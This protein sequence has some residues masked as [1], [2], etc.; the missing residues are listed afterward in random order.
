MS[1]SSLGIGSGIDLEGM[2]QMLM[3]VEARPLQM[4]ANKNQSFQT[5]LSAYSM[6]QSAVANF[7]GTVRGLANISQYQRTTAGSTQPDLATISAGSTASNGS[8]NLSVSQL[9]QSQRLVAGGVASDKEEIGTGKFTITFGQITGG[10]FNEDTGLYQSTDTDDGPSNPSFVIAGAAAATITITNDNNSLIG[11]RDAINA[12]GIGVTATIVN[13]GT[14]KPFRLTLTNAATGEKSSMQIVVDGDRGLEDLL[15]YDPGTAQNMTQTAMARNAEFTLDGIRI[16][17]ATNTVTDVLEGVTITLRG[18]SSDK[19]S[20]TTLSVNR[21]TGAAA[22]AV[23]ELVKAY[24]DL[25]NTLKELTSFDPETRQ[26]SVLTG[27]S[28]VRSIQT[29]MRRVLSQSI[30]GGIDGFRTLADVGVTMNK[31]GVLEIDS[32]RLNAAIDKD[33]NAFVAMFAEGGMS[34]NPAITFASAAG[35]TKT[36]SFEV[37]ITQ[38]ATKGHYALEIDSGAL[39]L[40]GTSDADRSM[41]ITL[42]GVSR[43]ITLS[44]KSYSESELATELQTQINNAFTGAGLNVTAEDGVLKLTSDAYGSATTINITPTGGMGDVLSNGTFT[45]GLDVAGTI[46]GIVGVG[47]GQTLT[48]AANS[49]TD[50]LKLTITGEESGIRGTVSFTKGYAYQFQMMADELLNENGTIRSHI[51]GMNRNIEQTQKEFATIEAR[52]ERTEKAYRR[53][54]VA[55]DVLLAKLNQQ[56]AYLTTQLQAISGLWQTSSSK[57]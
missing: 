19:A 41:L 36:G 49:E 53:Q 2:V 54:F 34:S 17:K 8:Y 38:V 44:E 16:S 5:K 6:V 9:A 20:T 21:D 11:I 12:A 43:T 52:I 42:N 31:D 1:I 7:Q 27:D 57:K 10:T 39:D 14:D 47:S 48:G 56:S 23:E 37:E 40:S 35:N 25:N 4:I 26:A 51:D 29:A 30:T 22:R 3:Q 46:N 18:V 55:L 13:D 33:F 50:G 28:A 32:S 45:Q 24:N 15:S